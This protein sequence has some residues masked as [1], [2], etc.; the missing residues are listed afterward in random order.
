MPPHNHTQVLLQRLEQLLL[1][2]ILSCLQYTERISRVI[3][4]VKVAIQN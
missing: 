2:E 1:E 4:I 3:Y